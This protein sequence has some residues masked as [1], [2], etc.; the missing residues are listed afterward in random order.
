M[1]EAKKLSAMLALFLFEQHDSVLRRAELAQVLEQADHMRQA[2]RLQGYTALGPALQTWNPA[3]QR[4][5]YQPIAH[6]FDPK[7]SAEYSVQQIEARLVAEIWLTLDAQQRYNLAGIYD[8]LAEQGLEPLSAPLIP[9]LPLV[10]VEPRVQAYIPVV[11]LGTR[12][13]WPRHSWWVRKLGWQRPVPE[14]GQQLTWRDQWQHTWPPF[15]RLQLAAIIS[16]LLLSMPWALLQWW[17]GAEP[18]VLFL[19]SFAIF[20]ALRWFGIIGSMLLGVVIWSQ[21][22]SA[23]QAWNR[24]WATT[25]TPPLLI[26]ELESEKQREQ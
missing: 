17:L 10:G 6:V 14:L 22:R 21:R 9:V 26:I 7:L 1:V 11:P 4:M 2:L 16:I 3:A 8:Q 23:I 12:A 20:T 25:P 5:L 18:Q 24:F 13:L 19:Q 15:L